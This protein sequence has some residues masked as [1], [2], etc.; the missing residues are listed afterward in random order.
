M[1]LQTIRI[2]SL[3]QVHS[4]GGAPQDQAAFSA[5]GHPFI[6]AGSL[7]KLLEGADEGSLERL[8][9]ETAKQHGLRLFPHG[10]VLFAKSGMSATKG[11]V[12]SLKKPAYV[13]SHL[14]A[15]LPY[16]P[17]DSAFLVRALQRFPPTTLI[18]DAAYPSIRLGDIEQMRIIAPQ[19]PV[20]RHRIAAI[21]DAADAM[22]AKRGVALAKLD[23]L[24]KSI[25]LDLFGDPL[26]NDKRWNR[27]RLCEVCDNIT[28][29]THDTPTRV[30][31]GIPF[32]TSKNIRAFE[33]DLSDLEFVTPETHREI[34][35]RCN[36]RHGDVLYTNIGVN[37]GNA[38]ANRLSFEFSLSRLLKNAIYATI[39]V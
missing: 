4:G 19:S 21:L 29:G 37:V 32:I 24:T 25:F 2:A 13:V 1:S 38:V 36:P 20:R 8:E 18:K 31:S 10:T 35:K 22:R 11:Y 26:R 33:F 39:L 28:D 12:Y 17:K 15:L 27:V 5:N 30:A 23:I 34:I 6:R 9:P 16:D 3:A 7:S 14:A